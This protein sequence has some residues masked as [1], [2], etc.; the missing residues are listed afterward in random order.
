MQ[1]A[2]DG[3][4]RPTIVIEVENSGGGNIIERDKID[5]VCR[6]TSIERHE[7]NRVYLK[8][9][10]VGNNKYVEGEEG[11]TIECRDNSI[12]LFRNQG[13]FTCELESIDE[14]NPAYNARIKAVLEYGYSESSSRQ[15]EIEKRN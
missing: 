15:V 9:L 6:G 11:N 14:N 8:E 1:A 4:V 7:W 5:S 13:R 10:Y 12:E 3:E 2:G